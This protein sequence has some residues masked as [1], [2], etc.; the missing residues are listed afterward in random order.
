MAWIHWTTHAGVQRVLLCVF[1]GWA[2]PKAAAP[3][4][5][6]P[7]SVNRAQQQQQQQPAKASGGTAGGAA[8]GKAAPKKAK[9][10]A[11]RPRT[12]NKKVMYGAVACVVPWVTLLGCGLGHHPRL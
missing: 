6:K 5:F 4:M 11:F 9:V 7:T 2:K 10:T 12:L 1:S 8:G 3:S